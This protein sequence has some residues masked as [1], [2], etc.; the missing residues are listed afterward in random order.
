MSSGVMRSCVG[1]N[2]CHRI[3][4]RPVFSITHAPR[5]QSGVKMISRSAGMDSTTC[6]ALALV[7]QMSDRAF[8]AAE[9]FT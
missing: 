3:I 1:Q 5:L 6:G 9:V 8:T 7:Q 2:P 4:D